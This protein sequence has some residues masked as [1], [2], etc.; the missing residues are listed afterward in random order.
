MLLLAGAAACSVSPAVSVSVLPANRIRV[1]HPPGAFNAEERYQRGH[2]L[3]VQRYL[4]SLPEDELS[5]SVANLSLYGRVLLARGDFESA[6]PILERARALETRSSRRGEIEWAICQGA[7][8]W[9]VNL[10]EK[11][12]PNNGQ[13]AFG[14]AADSERLYVALEDGTFAGI[15]LATGQ[16]AWIARL[17]SLDTLGAP[18]S[19]GENRT[20]GGLRFGQSAAVT[21]IPGVVFTG[22]WDG[23]LR[24]LA[25]TD[26]KILWQFD[27]AK[28]FRSVNGVPA[29]GGSMGG[30]GVTV[31]NG[32]VYAPSGYANVGGGMPGNVL[33]AFA[34]Q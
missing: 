1:P 33:L 4:E 13:I 2:Y 21:E 12:A 17:E 11:T 6:W 3:E 32:I 26:G 18:T 16:R 9:S 23:T 14:G 22:G 29:K 19:N 5:K 27:T 34:V 30:P 28:Q 7:V 8:L 15:D 10:S 20:K 25:T 24:A 31:V